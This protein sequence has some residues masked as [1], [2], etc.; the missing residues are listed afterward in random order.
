M[1]EDYSVVMAEAVAV[2]TALQHEDW[3]LATHLVAE[4]VNAAELAEGLAGLAV[5]FA[6]QL[7]RRA[8]VTV[9]SLLQEC[10]ITGAL[11]SLE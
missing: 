2:C 3:D 6:R 11:R 1:N 8:G 5:G 9:D 7:E 10:A 4:S